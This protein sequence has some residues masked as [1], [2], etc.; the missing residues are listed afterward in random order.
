MADDFIDRRAKRLREFVVVK[1]RWV[2]IVA[3]NEV[4]DCL[5]DE[6]SCHSC[7]HEGVA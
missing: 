5:I 1:R 3:D 2:C 7:L 6:V 4:V